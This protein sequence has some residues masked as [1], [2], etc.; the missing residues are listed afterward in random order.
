MQIG[1]VCVRVGLQVPNRRLDGPL[2][3]AETTDGFETIRDG[4]VF[5]LGAVVV[6]LHTLSLSG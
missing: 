5:K 1:I 2:V 6:G 3:Q 4:A